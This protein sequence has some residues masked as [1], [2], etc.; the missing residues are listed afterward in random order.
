[1]GVRPRAG[2]AGNHLHHASTA[3]RAYV[4]R[5][6]EQVLARAFGE[7][8]ALSLAAVGSVIGKQTCYNA[9]LD[10]PKNMGLAL[11]FAS[12]AASHDT[13]DNAAHDG[14]AFLYSSRPLSLGDRSDV[15]PGNSGEPDRDGVPAYVA[16]PEA[17]ACKQMSEFEAA[18]GLLDEL[19]AKQEKDNLGAELRALQVDVSLLVLNTPE[20]SV[21]RDRISAGWRK[22]GEA[23]DAVSA[24][25]AGGDGWPALATKVRRFVHLAMVDVLFASP[26]AHAALEQ[27]KKPRK[28]N[29]PVCKSTGTMCAGMQ[30]AGIYDDA[31]P[32]YTMLVFELLVPFMQHPT[33]G[34]KVKIHRG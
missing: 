22:L 17:A 2:M 4:F 19:V 15:K 26:E 33:K 21:T 29:A 1:M 11:T 24:H 14:I 30:L 12:D 25:D 27:M 5:P 18:G 23:S 10:S 28:R 32:I 20:E 31:V 7:A 16:G 13:L 6:T 9:V 3:E 8:Q 34:K